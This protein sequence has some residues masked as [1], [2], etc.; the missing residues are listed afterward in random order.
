MSPPGMH[1]ATL[2]RKSDCTDVGICV[3]FIK[4]SQRKAAAGIGSAV[5]QFQA[6]LLCS[7]LGLFLV[8]ARQ[9]LLLQLLHPSSG[10]GG[11][12]AIAAAFVSI[13]QESKQV[14]RTPSP[15]KQTST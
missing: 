2:K 11:G 8:A 3:S 12:R 13:Y 9:L 5:Q 14:P 6:Q 7:S 15:S 4:R 1:L 10:Q